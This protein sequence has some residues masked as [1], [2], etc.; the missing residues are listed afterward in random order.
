MRYPYSEGDLLQTP[1]RYHYTPFMGDEFMHAWR[2]SR[3]LACQRLPAPALPPV[4]SCILASA[5]DTLSLLQVMCRALRE[6]VAETDDQEVVDYWL[7]RLL[8]KFEVSKRLYVGYQAQP[9]HPPLAGSSYFA[10]EPYLWLSESLS[11][12]WQ[13]QSVGYFLSGFLKLNDTLISQIQHLDAEQ[14]AYLAWLLN[15]EQQL[16]SELSSEMGL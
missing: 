7:L 10:I 16:L 13:R 6:A 1:Q 14:G 15:M 3:R 8:K 2:L 9:P 12:A 5:D 11:R 4:T